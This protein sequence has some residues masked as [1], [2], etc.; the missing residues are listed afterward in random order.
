MTIATETQLKPASK[1]IHFKD[2]LFL[3]Q[4]KEGIIVSEYYGDFELDLDLALEVKSKIGEL[5]GGKRAPQLFI[6]SASLSVS[7][8]VREWGATED[9][10]TFSSKSA[11]IGHTLGQ[12]I[13]A[14]FLIKVQRPPRPTKL[15]STIDE[16][17]KWLVK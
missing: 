14:N 4:S 6:A 3:Y 5:T 11:I 7:K 15:F 1:P 16:A 2:R 10:Y 9:A 13:I 17:V 12:R 8:E